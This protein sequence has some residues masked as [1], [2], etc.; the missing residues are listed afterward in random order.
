M[1]AHYLRLADVC[2][3][4]SIDEALLHAVCA[5]GLVEIKHTV[6][7]DAVISAEDAE[8]LRVVTVL[9]RE[10]DVNLEGAAVILHMRE[11]LCAM[12]RQFDE[13]LH[14]LVDELRRRLPR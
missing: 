10:M 7:A 8:R 5:E 13:I 9:M 12:Q 2:V 1:T 14:T 3:Q 6:D 11:D 4:L